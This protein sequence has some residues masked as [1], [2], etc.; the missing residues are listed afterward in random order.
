[1]GACIFTTSCCL[2]QVD[3][4]RKGNVYEIIYLGSSALRV[5][6]KS[7]LFHHVLPRDSVKG[8]CV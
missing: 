7:V 5:Y 6:I 2:C 1:M 3:G 8:L 4:D